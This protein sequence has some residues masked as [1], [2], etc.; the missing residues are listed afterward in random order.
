MA[1]NAVKMSEDEFKD[2]LISFASKIIT[3]DNGETIDFTIE[4]IENDNK[5]AEM[6]RLD[7]YLYAILPYGDDRS[8]LA[9]IMK[10]LS[11]VH[12]DWENFDCA[13][14]E[15]GNDGLGFWTTQSGVPVLGCRA[16][17]DWEWPVHFVLYPESKTSIRAYL[18]KEGNTWNFKSKTAFGSEEEKGFERD[19]DADGEGPDLDVQTYKDAINKRLKAK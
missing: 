9:T 16:G 7:G 12:F 13:S 2:L 4:E 15:I 10:D 3:D 8:G 1:R 18:P 6:S 11:K 14:D 5:H 19:E 17:G